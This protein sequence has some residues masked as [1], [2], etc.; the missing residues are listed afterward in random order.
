MKK[1]LFILI[2]ISSCNN[3]RNIKID[4][5][6]IGS[7]AESF[8]N[9]TVIPQMKEPKPYEIVNTKVVV[10]TVADNINDYRFVYNHLSFNK[11]DSIENKRH[12]DSVINVSHN[13]DSVISIT[14][15][16]GYKTKYKR[17]DIVMD[18][19]KLKYDRQK[20]K[21]SLWPF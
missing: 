12:L 10:K 5:S 13:P 20:D 14:V 8:M 15:N 6:H 21:I 19:I 17:G 3:K 7:L 9:T 11:M 1:L 2:I 16:V 4:A 18:S